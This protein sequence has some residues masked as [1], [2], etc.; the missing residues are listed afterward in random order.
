VKITDSMI[1]ALQTGTGYGGDLSADNARR[2]LE[3]ALADV[4]AAEASVWVEDGEGDRWWQRTPG[5]W[6]CNG[7]ADDAILSTA[8]L[9]ERYGPLTPVQS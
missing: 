7:D 2:G 8:H 5:V 4:I 1:E 3:A 9:I 6:L